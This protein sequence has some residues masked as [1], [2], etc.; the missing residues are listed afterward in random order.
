ME[1]DPPWITVNVECI[2]LLEDG[3]LVD[4]SHFVCLLSPFCM[5]NPMEPLFLERTFQDFLV[6]CSPASSFEVIQMCVGLMSVYGSAIGIVDVICRFHCIIA[7]L[8][9][10]SR[11]QAKS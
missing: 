7:E 4:L 3:L 2:G 9:M 1:S 11:H 8:V 6:L 5:V 10:D